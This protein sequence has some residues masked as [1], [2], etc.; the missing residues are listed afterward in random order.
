MDEI[1]Q[2]STFFE[3]FLYSQMENKK[4]VDQ[5]GNS[6]VDVTNGNYVSRLL[7]ILFD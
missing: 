2:I 6:V 3:L 4:K 1:F 7:V 5:M